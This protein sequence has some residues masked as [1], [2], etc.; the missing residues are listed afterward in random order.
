MLRRIAPLALILTLTA[1]APHRRTSPVLPPPPLPG[2]V[3]VALTTE[4][5]TITL[6]LDVKHAPITATNFV[7]YTEQKRFDGIVFYRAMH[8]PWG[9]PPNGLIQAGTRGDPQRLLPPITHEPTSLTGLHHQ[10]GALSMARYAPGTATGDFSILISDMGGLD[11]DPA[12]KDAEAQAGYAVFG[13]VISG[14]DVV[15][16]IYDAPL[17][18]TKGEGVM[19]GQMLAAPVKVLTARRIAAPFSPS[20]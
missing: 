4:L 7:R 5:G 3:D 14:M 11:A 9:L 2:P 19:R 17:A 12:G 10:A 1:T 8:L 18:P 16:K 15:S 13:R 6:E 20:Q